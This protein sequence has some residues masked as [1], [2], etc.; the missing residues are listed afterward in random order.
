[1]PD[2]CARGVRDMPPLSTALQA[3][4]DVLWEET[5]AHAGDALFNG[6]VFTVDEITP[7]LLSAQM[8][9]FRRVVA[10]MERPVFGTLRLRR[11]RCAAWCA[12]ALA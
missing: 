4:A 2:I 8:T 5:R 1:M 11:S 3:E 7:H 6:R 9:E 12:A 10:Q